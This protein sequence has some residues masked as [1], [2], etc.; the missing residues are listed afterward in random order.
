MMSRR[1]SRRALSALGVVVC[2][3]L[4][5]GLASAQAIGGTVTDT[6]GGVLPGVTV[7]ARSP[8]IIEQVRA[9]ITDGNGQYLI[10]AL[11]PGTYSITYSLPGFGTLVRDEIELSTG[12]TASIDIELSVGD[13]A[14]TVT[15]SGASPVVDIQNVEQR[16]VM[17]REVID[18]IPTGKNMASYALL[19]PGMQGAQSYGMNVSQDAGGITAH[20]WQAVSI[21]GGFA[22]D[23]QNDLQGMDFTSDTRGVVKAVLVDGNYEEVAVEYSGNSAEVE[24]GGVRF[25]L[26]PREGSNQFNGAFVSNF[27]FKDLQANNVDQD[28]RNRGLLIGT[29]LDEVWLVNPSVGGPIVEDKLWFFVG[30]TSQRANVVAANTF[31]NSDPTS[32]VYVPDLNRP[33]IDETLIRDS[34]LHL[35]WQATTKDKVKLLWSHQKAEKPFSLQGETLGSIFLSPEAALNT[36]TPSEI[37]QATWTRPQTNRLLFEAGLSFWFDG[38]DFLE[39]EGAIPTLPGVLDVPALIAFRNMSS[40]FSGTT[41]QFHPGR[42]HGFRGS[43]SYVTGTHNVKVGIIGGYRWVNNHNINENDW[44]NLLTFQGAPIRANFRTPGTVTNRVWPKLGIYAQDQWTVD[45]VT[46]NAG[47]RFDY[48]RS[49]YPEQ[50]IEASTWQPAAQ[51]VEAKTAVIW[52]DLQPRLSVAY[53]LFGDGRT[54][55]KASAS[56]YGDRPGMSLA[57]A[58]NPGSNNTAQF[59]SWFDG[60]D[61]FGVGAPACIGPVACIAGD[62]LPQGDPFNPNP[63]G[64][65]LTS[66]NN[67]AFGTPTIN[68]FYDDDW[69]FGWGNRKTNWEFSGSV[70][71]ELMAGVSLD[72]GYFRRSFSNFSVQDNR[73]LAA[74]DFDQFTVAIPMD[75]NLPGGGGGTLTLFDLRPEAFGRAPNNITTSADPFGGE[76]QTWNGFDITMD[77]RIEGLLLQGGLSTGKTSADF[78]EL[79][80]AAPE[81]LPGRAGRV[82]TVAV[83]HCQFD[84]N[85]L[86]QIKLLGAYTLPHDV[87]IAATLQSIPGPERGADNTF[88]AAELAAA[89]GRPH[90]EGTVTVNVLDPGTV[91]GERFNQLDLRFTKILSLG[92]TVRLRAMFDI[93]NVFNANAVTK[94][95][96][97]LTNYLGPIAIMPG[98][99]GKFAFQLDF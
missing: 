41:R 4:V 60:A 83:D 37:Y 36:V 96:Y 40:W 79:M 42:N 50:I 70:Q 95:E 8:A 45:R 53:D 76:S 74:G 28:L 82:D 64:E 19:V 99:L 7:E 66:T 2:L 23:T 78:C 3:L 34:S 51:F 56:R 26:I 32:L 68:T 16:Q 67:P 71:R 12:F 94:E 15:V 9:G 1:R 63:N 54:A 61:P 13:I 10:I 43:M 75:P 47:V 86:T 91:Y 39:A 48:F 11:E 92:N 49:G 87:Q 98:R 80:L 30:H 33:S 90:T 35:T 46:V 44:T 73:A 29:E 93:Y 77:A 5:P 6:T 88:G 21:H 27:T 97:G 31:V 17:D 72:I 24:T 22:G 85:W 58:L 14:E 89:L 62:G 18:S 52:K 81:I 59:R 38:T 20:Q 25:N 84:T 55:L 69:A 57:G 65:L